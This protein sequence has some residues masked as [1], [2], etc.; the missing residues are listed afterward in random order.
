MNTANISIYN[1]F[2]GAQ[3]NRTLIH[4]NLRQPTAEEESK[5]ELKIASFPRDSEDS[6]TEQ[7][8][9]PVLC[10]SC[11][12]DN[13]TTDVDMDPPDLSSE[14]IN[15]PPSEIECHSDRHTF[16]ICADSQLGM[17]SLNAEWETEL[18]YCRKAVDRINALE[19]RPRFVSMCGDIVDME[20]SFYYNNP[21]ALKN[22]GLEDCERIQQQQFHDFQHVFSG[23]HPDIGI[24]C[25]C[26]NHDIGNRPTPQSIEKFR[27]AFGDEYLAFWVNGTYNIVLNNV[28]FV[29]PEGAEE[30]YSKQLHWLHDRLSYARRHHAAQIYVFGHHPWFLYS[31][32]ED[33]QDFNP[34]VG[35]SF[36][37]EWD[38]GSGRFDNAIFPDSY[39]SMPKKYRKQAMELFK[40]YNVNACFSGHFHQN[41][42]AKASFG[43]D[44]IVTGPLSM[45][46]DSAGKPAQPEGNGRGIRIVEVNV[47]ANNM[48]PDSPAAST[49]SGS[50]TH[51][52]ESLG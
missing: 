36:P 17:T 38:D 39:F 2:K 42:V 22:Y 33:F 1:R 34:G 23:I 50:F 7:L 18:H 13:D 20:N 12:P 27:D 44:M 52:F 24:V 31:D 37:P 48:K 30:M 6:L 3:R 26:G 47:N 14:R 49:R 19:P 28:L 15:V 29:N 9:S 45:V 40:E 4:P 16:V 21:K 43:M 11:T 46:F 5:H 25:L 10:M 8:N 32:E 35:S 51:R 41:L